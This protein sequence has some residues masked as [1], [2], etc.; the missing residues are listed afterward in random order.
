ML[1]NSG[2]GKA[3][4]VQRC[5]MQAHKSAGKSSLIN[6]LL[7]FP[8]IAKTVC[9]Y[10]YRLM[11]LLISWIGRYQWACTSVVTEYRQK[12]R[13]H[14]SPITIEVEYLSEREIDDLIKEQLWNY[15]QIFLPGMEDNT[16][17]SEDHE[18]LQKESEQAWSALEAGFKHQKEF[19]KELLSDVTKEGLEKATA[20]LVQWAHE[21]EW[22]GDRSGLGKATADTA[23]ECCEMTSVFMED[24]FWP[25]TKIIR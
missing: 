18:R 11:T 10:H 22:H 8:E 25:F 12:T 23:E 17:D 2:E 7:H 14:L 13:D 5:D 19:N 1:G 20:K 9:K 15:K 21:L 4:A 3:P 24:R 6:S 16:V